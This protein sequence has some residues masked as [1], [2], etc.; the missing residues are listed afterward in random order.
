MPLRP[1]HPILSPARLPEPLLALRLTP[2]FVLSLVLLSLSLAGCAGQAPRKD[3][4]V[5]SGGSGTL[6]RADPGF[7]QWLERQSLLGAAPEAAVVVSGSEIGWR[8]PGSPP[9]PVTASDRSRHV[10]VGG[11]PSSAHGRQ[12]LCAGRTGATSGLRSAT[13]MRHP[14]CLPSRGS[15]GGRRVGL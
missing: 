12:T 11:T 8:A 4:P 1:P 7:L 5:L 3:Q 14:R 6:G 13:G 2:L 10:A 9:C 15:R